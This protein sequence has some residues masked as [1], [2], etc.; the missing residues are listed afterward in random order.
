MISKIFKSKTMLFSMLIGILGAI[1]SS[2]PFMQ[3]V[4]PPK[5][6]GLVLMLVSVAIAILRIVTKKPLSEKTSILE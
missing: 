1:Q 4:I 2:M 6:Y 5:Y 3:D